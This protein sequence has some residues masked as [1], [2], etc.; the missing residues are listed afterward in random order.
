MLA[1]K[2][3]IPAQ[4]AGL[5]MQDMCQLVSLTIYQ[6]LLVTMLYE[7]LTLTGICMEYRNQTKCLTLLTSYDYSPSLAKMV[8]DCPTS[9]LTALLPRPRSLGFGVNMWGLISTATT[10]ILVLRARVILMAR[11]LKSYYSKENK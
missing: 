1:I 3:E 4:T 2:T 6:T 11:Y 7:R 5:R 9:Y 10:H 8:K